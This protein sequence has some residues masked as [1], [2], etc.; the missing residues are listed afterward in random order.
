MKGKIL[1][2]NFLTE[3]ELLEFNSEIDRAALENYTALYRQ[4]LGR[5]EVEFSISEETAR[6][7]HEVFARRRF[8]V[9]TRVGS[10]VKYKR[11]EEY[12]K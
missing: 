11:F 3:E 7:F 10:S 4:H 2:V 8:V 5:F 9:S 1:C 6:N 12:N